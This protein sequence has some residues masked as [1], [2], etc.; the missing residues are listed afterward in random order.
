MPFDAGLPH[1][2]RFPFSNKFKI[3]R[4]LARFLWELLIGCPW[5]RRH[6]K[7]RSARCR[8]SPLGIAVQETV[9]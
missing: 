7:W 3:N 1:I 6:L 9:I 5:A 2:L 8:I 4:H